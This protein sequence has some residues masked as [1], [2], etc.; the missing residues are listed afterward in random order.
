MANELI[1]HYRKK[2]EHSEALVKQFEDEGELIWRI[3]DWR[4]LGRYALLRIQGRDFISAFRKSAIP[5]ARYG[6]VR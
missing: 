5:V 3:A 6:G 1:E 2:W 4:R